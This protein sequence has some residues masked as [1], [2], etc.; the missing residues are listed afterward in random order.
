MKS[1]ENS[2]VLIDGV[3]EIVKRQI[4]KEEGRFL[5]AL[6][7][8]L[9]VSLVPP[10]ISSVVKSISERGVRRVGRGY[11]NKIFTSVQSFEQYWDC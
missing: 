3:T 6:L 1:L 10:V 8:P 5:G 2:G 4:K 9:A 7:V 11:M